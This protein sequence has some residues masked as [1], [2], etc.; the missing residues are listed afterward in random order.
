MPS[1]TC[2]CAALPDMAAVPMGGDGLDE[3]VFAT[4]EQI[5][6]HGGR[7]WW[8]YASKCSQC[9]QAWMVAQDERIHDN[10]YLKRIDGDT[11]SGIITAA[12]WPD[13]FV[14]YEQ[15]LRLG[16]QP[17]QMCVFADPEDPALAATVIDLRQARPDIGAD[18]ISELL[19]IPFEAAMR[20]LQ[21]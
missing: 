17:G 16:Q 1:T 20:L 11:L 13:D 4:L 15:V 21:A 3:R 8:L 7:Q 5:V 12:R 14:T 18:E 10:F 9:G 6:E 2:E 19:N